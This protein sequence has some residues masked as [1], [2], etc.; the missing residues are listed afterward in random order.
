MPSLTYKLNKASITPR[1]AMPFVRTTPANGI[2]GGCRTICLIPQAPTFST[3]I[4]TSEETSTPTYAATGATATIDVTIVNDT[5]SALT[6]VTLTTSHD[7][8]GSLS[9]GTVPTTMV[10][11]GT[12]VVT[13]TYT[14]A[15]EAF[16]VT[17]TAYATGTKSDATTATSNT[18]SAVLDITGKIPPPPPP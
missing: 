14:T 15:S 5:G 6:S 7:G 16:D 4:A 12:F 10:N 1:H 2:T 18:V 11:A 17:V 13:L 8:N 9:V 3:L